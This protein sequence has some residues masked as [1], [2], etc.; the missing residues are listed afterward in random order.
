MTERPILFSGEM[1]KA[2]LDGRKTQTRRVV[3]GVA[4]EALAPGMFV[5]EFVA[6]QENHYCPY[7]NVG[8]CLWVRETL[9]QHS[10]FGLPLGLIPQVN[11]GGQ[12]V[13]SYAAD[14]H[15]DYQRKIPGIHMPRWASRLTL[16]IASI[17]VERIQDISEADAIAEGVEALKGQFEGC[18]V[19]AGSGKGSDHGAMSG[20]TAKDCYSRLWDAINAKRGFGW[21]TN[22][23]AWVIEFKPERNLH[24]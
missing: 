16:E 14:G 4:L 7:G 5:P 21:D 13:W 9:C 2:I 1:V 10:Y 8:D 24:A 15:T 18:F 12:R 11:E 22:P 19:V 17:R 3:K 6:S 23:W 20:T